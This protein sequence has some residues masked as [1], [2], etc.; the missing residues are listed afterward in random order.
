MKRLL[1]CLVLGIATIVGVSL[2]PPTQWASAAGEA[3]SLP[4]AALSSLAWPDG[5]HSDSPLA[6]LVLTYALNLAIFSAC[7]YVLVSAAMA[8][9]RRREGGGDT[10]I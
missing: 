10:W 1:V 9:K 3:M 2:L 4:G 8:V 7:W 6:F 5:T